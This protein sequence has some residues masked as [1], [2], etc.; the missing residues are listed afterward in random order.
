[1]YWGQF[2][3]LEVKFLIQWLHYSCLTLYNY[4]AY[5]MIGYLKKPHFILLIL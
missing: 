2:G 5:Q 3:D 1:M 4:Q